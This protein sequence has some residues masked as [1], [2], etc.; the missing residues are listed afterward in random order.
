MKNSILTL[1]ITL[2]FITPFIMSAQEVQ[3]VHDLFIALKS[4]PQTTGDVIAFEKA[5]AGKQLA[6]SNL[7][8]T[9]TA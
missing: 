9:I 2:L 8:P 1:G 4:H 7:F 5:A 3:S 6:F